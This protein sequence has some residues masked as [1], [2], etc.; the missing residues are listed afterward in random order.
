MSVL[1]EAMTRLLKKR[2]ETFLI[3]P[4]EAMERSKACYKMGDVVPKW[5]DG[6]R[7]ARHIRK[8]EMDGLTG[9]ILFDD[10]GKRREFGVDVVEMTM[11]SETV[12]IG[13]WKDGVGFTA[14]PAK[15]KKV[16]A[17][18]TLAADKIYIVTSILVEMDGLTGHILFD[19][20][21][22][23]REFGV[24][25][26]EMTMHSETVKIGGWKDGVGFTAVPA[27]YKKVQ[28]NNTLAADKIYIVTSILVRKGGFITPPTEFITRVFAEP[29]SRREIREYC[30]GSSRERTKGGGRSWTEPYLMLKKPEDG[31]VLEGNDR[32]EGY[33]K[34]LIDLIAH[35]VDFKW[36]LL[37]NP[38]LCVNVLLVPAA[39]LW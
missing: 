4:R 18:N 22:K 30:Q 12:K 23:R 27:K 13:G 19:D 35:E 16:Q 29:R 7:L 31:E 3:N 33:C 38:A 21:G 25:V 28:A 9:H 36:Y 32:Y 8:V 5:Q 24:D 17:N 26:V 37:M 11:H 34:D 39:F 1:V 6:E 20:V 10:V 2:P 15:Y 14:V